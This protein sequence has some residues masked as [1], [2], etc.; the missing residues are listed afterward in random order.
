MDATST[1]FE[2]NDRV[3]VTEWRFEPGEETGWHRHELD[4]TVVPIS[5]GTLTIVDRSG[6]ETLN[7]MS[8]GIPYFRYAGAEH[9]VI[10]RSDSELAFIEIEII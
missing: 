3:R 2:D 7:H 1:I 9:N 5:T 6:T 4:Y 8:D 10:N